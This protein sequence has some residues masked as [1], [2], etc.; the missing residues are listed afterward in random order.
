MIYRYYPLLTAKELLQQYIQ[1]QTYGYQTTLPVIH[2]TKS[3]SQY[4]VALSHIIDSKLVQIVVA[5]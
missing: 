5:D 4:P 2:D 3:P 1:E